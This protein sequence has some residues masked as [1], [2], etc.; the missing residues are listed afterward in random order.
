MKSNKYRRLAGILVILVF[1]I[2]IS[3]KDMYGQSLNTSDDKI[4]S[5]KDVKQKEEL[6][7]RKTAI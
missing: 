3:Q 6:L 5:K 1:L 4:E 7:P 2:S